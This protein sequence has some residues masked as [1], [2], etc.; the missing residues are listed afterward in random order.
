MIVSKTKSYH[1]TVKN[2]YDKATPPEKKIYS[3]RCIVISS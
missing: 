1:S 3:I 2:H